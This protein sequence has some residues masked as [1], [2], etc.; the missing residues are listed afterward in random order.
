MRDPI[1]S[2]LEG[3]HRDYDAAVAWLIALS[4]TRPVRVIVASHN[5]T[6]IER[7]CETMAAHDI[8]PSS[9]TVGFAQLLGTYSYV[10]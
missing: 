1:Q 2:D 4:L 7:A 10:Y 3:T 8:S 6:S 9:G 5:W